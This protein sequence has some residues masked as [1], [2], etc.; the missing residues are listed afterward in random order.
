[1]TMHSAKGLE[2]PVVFIVGLEEGLTPHRTSFGAAGDIEEERRLCYVAATRAKDRLY[3][4]C[5]RRRAV[6]GAFRDQVPSRFLNEIPSDL[7]QRYTGYERESQEL[8]ASLFTVGRRVKHPRWGTGVVLYRT[9]RGDM[10]RIHVRFD[11][12]RTKRD[13]VIK[14]SGLEL[15]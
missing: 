1:M 2:F 4:T 9:G 10:T 15:L 5:A 13:L 6:L 8:D 14:Y 3:L 7:L 11:K 12:D